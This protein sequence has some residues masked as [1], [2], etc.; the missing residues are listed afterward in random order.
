M[1]QRKWK[2][3]DLS[4]YID[5][6]LDP[7]TT[8]A[9]QARLAEDPALRQR[10][11]E[12]REV[13]DLLRAVPL[14]EP[15][16]NYLLTPAMVA[17]PEPEPER[18]SGFRLPIWAMRLATSLTAAAFVITV[19]LSLFQQGLSPRAMMEESASD[20]QPEMMV[21]REAAP[22]AE[23]Y[24]LEAEEAAPLEEAPAEPEPTPTPQGTLTPKEEMALE[25]MPGSTEGEP[26]GMG[27]G[28]EPPST[29]EEKPEGEMEALMEET[30]ATERS[31][32]ETDAATEET[33]DKVVREADTAQ[34]SPTPEESQPEVAAMEE[35][36]QAT[37]ETLDEGEPEALGPPPSPPVEPPEPLMGP[38]RWRWAALV[39]GVLTAVLTALTLWMSR[40]RR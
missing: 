37:V 12:V 40:N 9:L 5:G 36:P 4:A 16:R 38:S 25:A 33:E 7:E 11:D 20:A 32:D 2:D 39:T 17:E 18:R 3:R 31:A 10:L 6:E 28:G 14:R 34:P 35:A 8:Q 13:S 1:T 19:S 29:P 21:A 15:P 23:V 30:E 26:Q 24:D 22:T 27:G